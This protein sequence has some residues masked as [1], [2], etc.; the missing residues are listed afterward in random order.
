SWAELFSRESG[1]EA[2]DVPA[3]GVLHVEEER[4][5]RIDVTR[6]YPTWDLP[7]IFSLDDRLGFSTAQARQFQVRGCRDTMAA[8]A[9]R[10]GERSRTGGVVPPGAARAIQ[11]TKAS[12]A[13]VAAGWICPTERCT[14]RA[15]CDL[16]ASDERAQAVA[17]GA[18]ASA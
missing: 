10:Y 8:L 14:L 11:L 1:I 18:V 2:G 13:T 6:V 3:A 5:V 9:S 16:V 12:G 4:L 7:W 15:T 17:E